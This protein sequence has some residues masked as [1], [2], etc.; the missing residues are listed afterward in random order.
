MFLRRH[1]F[2]F[3]GHEA[4]CSRVFLIGM[5]T[6]AHHRPPLDAGRIKTF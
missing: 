6:P 5:V 1:Y 4:I 2:H 3:A